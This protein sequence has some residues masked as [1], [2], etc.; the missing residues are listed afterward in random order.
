MT[1]QARID[2]NRHNALRSTGP[3]TEEGKQASSRNA[4]KHGLFARLAPTEEPAFHD[5]LTGLYRSLRPE[6]EIQQLLVDQIGFAYMRR[7]RMYEQMDVGDL[8]LRYETML[9]RQIERCLR[10]LW[11]VKRYRKELG[12][13][14][15]ADPPF[16]P[17]FAPIEPAEEIVP[18]SMT[19]PTETLQE[20]TDRETEAAP[21]TLE[22]ANAEAPAASDETGG[23]PDDRPID[24]EPAEQ[25]VSPRLDPRAQVRSHPD[26]PG[27]IRNPDRSRRSAL[28]PHHLEEAVR[29]YWRR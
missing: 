29:R 11:E 24:E 12:E 21:S 1:S 5:M 16:L 22:T 15:D 4:T 14:A 10:H 27:G 8:L 20:Q 13:E 25:T 3:R 26:C 2:A 28:D 19:P 18:S 17:A 9:D 23:S 6:D 7:I